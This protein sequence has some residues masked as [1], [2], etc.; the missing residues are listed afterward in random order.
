M[1]RGYISPFRA[2][3]DRVR[4]LFSEGSFVEVFV[5]TPLKECERRDVKGLY[6]K[7]RRGELKDFT[8]IDSSYEEPVSPD[9]H[10]LPGETSLQVCVE[11][12]LRA[13]DEPSTRSW[14]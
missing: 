10:L 14:S 11:T 8:G 5:D 2:D 6:A 4:A 12:L 1:W 13:L 7:A 3:R 9:V